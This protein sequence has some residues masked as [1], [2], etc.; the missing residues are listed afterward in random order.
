MDIA[1]ADG[2]QLTGAVVTVAALAR[3]SGDKL[4]YTG[5]VGTIDVVQ[6]NAYTLTLSGP[7]AS[8]TT[9]RH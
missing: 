5:A 2:G 7:R 1:N 6:T 8:P 9:K 3:L 4:T